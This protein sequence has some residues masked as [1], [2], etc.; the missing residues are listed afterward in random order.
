MANRTL[1]FYGLAYGDVPVQVNAHINGQL[2]FTG[3]V[4][5]VPGE[6]PLEP[7]YPMPVLFSIV[8]SALY[9]TSYSGA[10]PM[11]ISVATG[12]GIDVG[13][14]FSNYISS[15]T[16][17]THCN[18]SVSGTTL[19]VE[20][21]TNDIPMVIGQSLFVEIDGVLTTVG[22]IVSGSGLT[23]TLDK[24]NT[25]L[26]TK[27]ASQ[28]VGSADSYLVNYN[29]HPANEDQTTDCRSSVTI[30][31]MAETGL[32]PGTVGQKPWRINAGSTLG[33]NFNVSVGNE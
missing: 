16:G 25:I 10:Y 2:V 22:I 24:T 3:A 13:E 28:T 7:V 6:P 21:F 15:P 12:N 17:T 4:P 26:L 11:T 20:S 31:G 30:D 8:E 23:W 5:T 27:M 14:V 9:P 33:C 19:T 29:G 1:Q 32:T 18:G